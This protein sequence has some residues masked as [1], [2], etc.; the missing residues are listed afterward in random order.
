MNMKKILSLFLALTFVFA[1]A[2]CGSD[3][4]DTEP[5][6]TTDPG[7]QTVECSFTAL[8]SGGETVSG[9]SFTLTQ[10]SD[11]Y[12]LVTGTDGTVKADLKLGKYSISYNSDTIPEG[13]TADLFALEVTEGSAA[14]SLSFTDNTPDGSA[15]KPYFIA[16]SVTTIHLAAGEELYYSYRGAASKYVE[17]KSES[18]SVTYN[19]QVYAPVDGVVQVQL[20]PQ[21]GTVTNFSVKNTSEAAI[22]TAMELISPL[23]SSENPIVLTE[24]S[25][26]AQVSAGTSLCYQ[27]VADKSGV[28]VVSS[29]NALNNISMVNMTTNA[30]SSQ[31]SGSLCEYMLVSAGDEIVITVSSISPDKEQSIDF[32]VA[33]YLGTREDPIPVLKDSMDISLKAS[34]SYVFTAN[35]GK[36]LKVTDENASVTFGDQTYTPNEFGIITLS[37]GGNDGEKAVFTLNNTSESLNG[38]EFTLE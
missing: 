34:S 38:I 30:V 12:P 3:P 5:P 7:E 28:I 2:A 25:A 13:C 26:V 1:L 15:E 23:G 11:T 17:I 14:F 10:G 27:W 31:T 16:D 18:V 36:T 20:E 22:E 21:I 6:E 29:S 8:V 19:G 33:V 37:F 24:S 4:A 32:A 9:L 35:A